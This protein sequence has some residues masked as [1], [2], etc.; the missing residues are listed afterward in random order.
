MMKRLCPKFILIAMMV[1]LYYG[2]IV[3]QTISYGYDAAGNRIKREIIIDTQENPSKKTQKITPIESLG[4]KTIKIYPNPTKGI[5]KVEVSDCTEADNV[6][7]TIYNSSGANLKTIT[8]QEP[9][10]TIDITD[11]AQGIYFMRI[12]ILDKESTWKIIK[13]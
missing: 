1:A 10:T 3:S 9:T 4:D 2:M 13:E 6:T 7:L 12:Q 5:L 8:V 11:Y